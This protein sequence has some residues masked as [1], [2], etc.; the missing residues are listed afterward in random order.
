METEKYSTNIL[1]CEKIDI[2]F[3]IVLDWYDIENNWKWCFACGA[4]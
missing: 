3:M 4:K 1:F 2:S